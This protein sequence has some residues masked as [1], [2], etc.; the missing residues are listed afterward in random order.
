MFG[1]YDKIR[2]ERHCEGGKM[3]NTVTAVTFIG[4]LLRF[5]IFFVTAVTEPS[6]KTRSMIERHTIGVALEK[7]YR[8]L[9]TLNVPV[10]VFRFRHLSHVRPRC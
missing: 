8:S 2:S 6:V 10:E 1:F 5:F 4:F 7:W 9:V 3:I